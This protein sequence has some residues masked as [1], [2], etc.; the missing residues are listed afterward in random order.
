MTEVGH[1]LANKKSEEDWMVRC[2]MSSRYTDLNS[3]HAAREC[4]GSSK[5]EG[6]SIIASFGCWSIKENCCIVSFQ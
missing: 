1:Y 4:E 3:M 6:S 2:L 5:Y